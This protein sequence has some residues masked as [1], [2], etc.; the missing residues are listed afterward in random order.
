MKR[1]KFSDD[2]DVI[3]TR[4]SWLEDQEQWWQQQNKKSCTSRL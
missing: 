1:Q 4:N 2:K 3:W